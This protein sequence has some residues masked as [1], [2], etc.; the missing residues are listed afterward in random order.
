MLRNIFRPRETRFLYQ[1]IQPLLNNS[2]GLLTQS[3]TGETAGDLLGVTDFDFLKEKARVYWDWVTDPD[4]NKNFLNLVESPESLALACADF[5]LTRICFLEARERG[6]YSELLEAQQRKIEAWNSAS[7]SSV[8]RDSRVITKNLFPRYFSLIGSGAKTIE[9]R[10]YKPDSSK[11]YPGIQPGDTV[12]FN[13]S[14]EIQ[15]WQ[16]RCYEFGLIPGEEMTATVSDVFFSPLVQWMFHSLELC[17]GEEFQ[18][19]LHFGWDLV[20]TAIHNAARYYAIQE[21]PELIAQHGFVGIRLQDVEI[22]PPDILL[23]AAF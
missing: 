5:T 3:T 4:L 13:I 21:Y 20:T 11:D 1:D 17:A 22:H 10:A 9:G 8:A 18:P 19:E 14:T 15:N 23:P 2:L 16:E 7:E 6:P 12:H